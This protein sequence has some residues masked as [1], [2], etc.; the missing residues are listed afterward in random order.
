MPRRGNPNW[1]KPIAVRA[2]PTEFDLQVKRL[3]LTKP[4]YVDSVA[5]RKWCERN[6]NRVYI[7]EWLLDAWKLEVG[8]ASATWPEHLHHSARFKSGRFRPTES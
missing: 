5:L 8:E 7:P 6:L 4:E 2:L 3:R 1:G